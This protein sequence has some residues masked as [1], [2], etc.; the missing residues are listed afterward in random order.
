MSL[1]TPKFTGYYR[2]TDILF[3]WPDAVPEDYR[4]PLKAILAE[5]AFIHPQ[6]PLHRDGVDGIYTFLGT[7]HNGES[8]YL[9]SSHQI[10]YLRYWLHAMNLTPGV[11]PLPHSE[12]LISPS[13][14]S[15]VSPAVHPTKRALTKG[16]TKLE[17]IYKLLKGN[18]ELLARRNAFERVR[19]FWAAKVGFWCAMDFE[20]W[21]RDHTAITEFGYSS[22]HWTDG[23]E[24]ADAGHLTVKKNS[25]LRNTTYMKVDHREHYKFGTSMEVTV[26]QLKSTIANLISQTACTGPVFLVFHA[27]RGD[28]ETLHQLEAPVGTAVYEL[29]DT[30]PSEGLFIVDTATLFAALIGLGRGDNPGLEQTCTKLGIETAYL[31]N[32][33]NDAH[34]TWLA[35]R[36][37]AAGES[38]DAQ[39][40]RRWPRAPGNVEQVQVQ[41]PEDQQDQPDQD[42]YPSDEE[43]DHE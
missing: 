27:A 37:M 30:T 36:E 21:E 14:L 41:F 9:F 22:V 18:A 16:F 42:D 17:K 38:L 28:M 43:N 25:A 26:S 33:G 1:S 13:E 24:V 6:H 34:Y 39:K 11:V 35:L 31:H 3:K 12:R 23:L 10:D 8:R 5:D 7:S 2:A 4:D 20:T 29:P 15:T 19:K 40:E 32:A